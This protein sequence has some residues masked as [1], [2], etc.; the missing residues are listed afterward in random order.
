MVTLRGK[1]N[2]K[3][4]PESAPYTT[5]SNGFWL[6]A[7]RLNADKGLDL[8]YGGRTSLEVFMNVP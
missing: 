6:G 8:V 7:A 2:G 4:G 3:F 5:V 1:G